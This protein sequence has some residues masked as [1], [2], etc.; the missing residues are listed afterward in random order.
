MA[1]LRIFQKSNMSPID[2][3][4]ISLPCLNTPAKRQQ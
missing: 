1:H 3:E 4:V 2:A